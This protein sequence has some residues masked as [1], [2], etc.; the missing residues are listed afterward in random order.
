MQMKEIYAGEYFKV[1]EVILSSGQV[2][3]DH[4]ADSDAFVFVKRGKG[5]LVFSDSESELTQGSS[6]FIPANKVHRLEIAE[7]FNACVVFEKDGEI[8]FL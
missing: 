8:E 2:M 3:P 6:I 5:K 7:D 1:K 4:R